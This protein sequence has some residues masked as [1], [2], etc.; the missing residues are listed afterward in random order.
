MR[1]FRTS[2]GDEGSDYRSGVVSGVAA[3][4]LL[5]GVARVVAWVL[6]NPAVAEIQAWA[7]TL[8]FT[9]LDVVGMV[10]LLLLVWMIGLAMTMGP[11]GW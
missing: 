6:E 3:T 11:R 4:F 9:P 10:G 5:L 7:T 2:T 8:Q 1:G